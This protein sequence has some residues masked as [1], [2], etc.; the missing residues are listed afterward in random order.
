MAKTSTV[1]VSQM[2]ADEKGNGNFAWYFIKQNYSNSS[3]IF[4]IYSFIIFICSFKVCFK[5]MLPNI[6]LQVKTVTCK[7]PLTLNSVKEL[8][9]ITIS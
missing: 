2:T 1:E 7:S 6:K 8:L 4:F 9:E 3:H 5:R